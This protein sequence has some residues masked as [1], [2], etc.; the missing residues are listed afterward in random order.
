MHDTYTHFQI[1]FNIDKISVFLKYSLRFKG[2]YIWVIELDNF[3]FQ[4]LYIYSGRILVLAY[5][6]PV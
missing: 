2:S 1:Y 4:F 6:G 5:R 3:S